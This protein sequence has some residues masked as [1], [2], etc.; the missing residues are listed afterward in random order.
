MLAPPQDYADT[1]PGT[2][3]TSNASAWSLSA[4]WTQARTWVDS[5]K[6]SELGFDLDGLH[7]CESLRFK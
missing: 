6:C 5:R 3:S 7:P 1:Q 2:T 4:A